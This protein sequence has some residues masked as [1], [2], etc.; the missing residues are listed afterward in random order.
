MS[1]EVACTQTAK[2]TVSMKK[3]WFTSIFSSR[4]FFGETKLQN[5]N[6]EV[7]TK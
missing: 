3:H 6:R 7:K 5:I 2:I 4:I 1:V